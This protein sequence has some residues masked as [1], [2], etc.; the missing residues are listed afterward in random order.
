MAQ[1][2]ESQGT[3][4]D[5]RTHE[6]TLFDIRTIIGLLLGIYGVV[7]VITSFFTPQEQLDKAD[8]VDVNLWA[9]LGLV[10]ASFVFIAWARLRPIEV[11]D[12][13]EGDGS[14]A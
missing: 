12:D 9:G 13:P 4:S 5:A 3:G 14:D 1:T 8:G 2:Q 7:L 11:P 10:V 6:A